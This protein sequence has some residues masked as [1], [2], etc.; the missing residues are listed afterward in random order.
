MSM[1]TIY[2]DQ[3][4]QA[5][6]LRTTIPTG[7]QSELARVGVSFEQWQPRAPLAAN[8]N[9]Q[10]VMDAYAG[11][12]EKLKQAEGYQTVDIIRVLPGNEKRHEIRAKFLAEHTHDDDEARFFVEGSGTFYLHIDGHVYMILCESGDF[13]RVPKNISHWFDMG[14]SPFITAIRFFTN[15]EGW[16]PHFTGENFSETF[17]QH[18]PQKEAA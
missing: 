9:D 2:A 11:D 1:L 16:I 12:I 7:M 10:D 3:A 17:P 15:A 4:P 8:A 13:I 14:E 6:V 5:P 18:V